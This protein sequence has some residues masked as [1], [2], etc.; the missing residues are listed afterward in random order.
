MAQIHPNAFS[1]ISITIALILSCSNP[2]NRNDMK[3]IVSVVADT[4]VSVKDSVFLIAHT[5]E[6]GGSTSKFIWWLN[7]KIVPLENIHDSVSS[8]YFQVNDTGKHI[9]S[10]QGITRNNVASAVETTIVHVNLNPPHIVRWQH[11]TTI[12]A[13]DSLLL[14]VDAIDPN[15]FVKAIR[16]NLDS[17][18][19]ILETG[20]F[21]SVWFFGGII[22]DHTILMTALDDDSI[23]S[24]PETTKVHII[25]D[26]PIVTL[27]HDTTISIRDSLWITA[28]RIDTFS[29]PVQYLWAQ[30]NGIFG[31]TTQTGKLCVV[32]YK[33]DIGKQTVYV[34]T[35][36]NHGLVSN[37]D[38]MNIL[39]LLERP[40]VTM[41]KDTAVFINDSV[42]ITAVGKVKDPIKSRILFYVWS[43]NGKAF[44]DTT[45]SGILWKRFGEADTGN[46]EVFVK[47]VDSDTIESFPDSMGILVKLGLPYLD[48][49]NDTSLVRGDTLRIQLHGHDENGYIGK[50]YAKIMGANTFYDSSTGGVF[51]ITNPFPA[52]ETLVFGARDDDGLFAFDTVS[53]QFKPIPCVLSIIGQGSRDTVIIHSHDSKVIKTPLSFSATLSNNAQDTFTYVLF[54][55]ASPQ[56]LAEAYRGS[57]P[58]CTLATSD[59]GTYFLKV[60]AFDTHRDSALSP[61]LQKTILMQN[62]VCFIGHSIVVG[63][64]GDAGKGGFRRTVI[65]SLRWQ[66]GLPKRIGCEGPIKTNVLLPVA[67]DST[68]CENG[69]T[70]ADIYDSL[71]SHPNVNADL[72]VQMIGTNEQYAFPMYNA[73]YGFGNFAVAAIDTMHAR[74]PQSEIY[75]LN[76]IPLPKD[77]IAPGYNIN[78]TFRKNLYVFNRMLDT[79]VLNRRSLWT[80]KGQSGV[81]LVDVFR[82]LS[83]LPVDSSYNPA[84]YS[85]LIHPNQ[86][87]YE[88]I[89][90]ELLK[91]MRAASSRFYYTN[92]LSK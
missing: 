2:V 26:Y 53:I 36:N 87:G 10:L 33:K 67:D 50:Y 23:A 28:Q 75:V 78:A 61:L 11:D 51:A 46:Q 15:G 71:L 32:F 69:R 73:K 18:K 43:F 52:I 90:Q 29:N 14:S 30:T 42:A 41:S 81:W 31:D 13:N 72:W 70:S 5:A 48:K 25:A 12:F 79:A 40:S 60:M 85:D 54:K 64:N 58:N 22:R 6:A 47:A 88:R 34:K 82:P 1:I 45:F 27:P 7:G 63:L 17:G 91:I 3:P 20:S 59:T 39:V 8:F 56:S 19:T 77:T 89:G 74:N 83:Q 62:R 76:G 55:G 24:S 68:L 92:L 4:T 21:S 9:I 84:Y 37:P 66:A 16:W 44:S 49:T 86:S 38:S 57:V 80:L 35:I 65:D